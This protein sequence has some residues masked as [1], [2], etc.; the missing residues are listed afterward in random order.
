MKKT[1]RFRKYS[2]SA[3][4]CIALLLCSFMT[5]SA[6]AANELLYTEGYYTYII[7]NN[8]ATITKADASLSGEVEIPS[9]LGGYTVTAIRYNAFEKN[10]NITKVTI[11]DSVKSIG[12]FA[13]WYC[14]NLKEVYIPDGVEKI[15]KSSFRY[16]GLTSVNIPGSV[17]TIESIAF[18]EC[19][20]LA[21]IT[22]SE[23][24]ESIESQA[25][26][27]CAMS[28][29]VFPDSVT[30]ISSAVCQSCHNLTTVKLGNN[31]TTIE[32]GVFN[33]CDKLTEITIPDSVT[34]IGDTAFARTALSEITIPDSV[35]TIGA[36]MF[37]ECGDLTDV[38]L[39]KDITILPRNLFFKCRKLK[40]IMIPDGITTLGDY[41]FSYTGIENITIPDSV[42]SIGKCAFRYCSDLTDIRIPD[43]ISVISDSMFANCEKLK[44]ITI[45]ASVTKIEDWAFNNCNSL[46]DIYF[47][48]TE[49]QW[50]KISIDNTYNSNDKIK[51]NP[52]LTIHYLMPAMAINT[53]VANITSETDAEAN[54][55]PGT[56][57]TA[58]LSTITPNDD[59]VTKITWIYGD[60]EAVYDSESDS[61]TILSGPGAVL[62]GLILDWGMEEIPTDFNNLSANTVIP[63]TVLIT[64]IE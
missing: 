12:S 36:Y 62:F 39:G 21:S 24:I 46:T 32:R 53:F 33:N 28:E 34:S 44:E 10:D 29:I 9:T 64:K 26:D 37:E 14:S 41:V 2:I 43:G 50:K 4:F 16:T 11:P 57:A 3:V 48:G 31:V 5:L 47:K 52:K 45:P 59:T 7:E 49:D 38:T 1:N 54:I 19:R 8:E 15:G 55:T 56:K 51:N 42:T 13:F 23:G 20:N 40:N 60:K 17:K 25:F 63:E 18:S 22:L 30:T 27:Y 6:G 61:C 35:T 58:V